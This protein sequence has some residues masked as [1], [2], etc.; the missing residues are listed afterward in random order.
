MKRIRKDWYSTYS[1]ANTD[2]QRLSHSSLC[3]ED[4]VLS[5]ISVHRDGNGRSAS[6][7]IFGQPLAIKCLYGDRYSAKNCPYLEMDYLRCSGPMHQDLTINHSHQIGAT[8][9]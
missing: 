3:V 7:A 9:R 1:K 2:G 6:I 5:R 8:Q 4:Q